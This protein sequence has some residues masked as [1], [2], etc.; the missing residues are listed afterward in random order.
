MWKVED[1]SSIYTYTLEP[2][3]RERAEELIRSNSLLEQRVLQAASGITPVTDHKK[4]ISS[5]RLKEFGLADKPCASKKERSQ[6]KLEHIHPDVV[7]EY[8]GYAMW[9]PNKNKV[10]G[11]SGVNR[12]PPTGG[13]EAT[14][15]V[16]IDG[17]YFGQFCDY[18]VAALVTGMLH[19]WGYTK[20]MKETKRTEYKTRIHELLDQRVPSSES[21]QRTRHEHESGSGF[22]T[23]ESPSPYVAASS[24]SHANSTANANKEIKNDD[25]ETYKTSIDP[26]IQILCANE[27]LPWAERKANCLSSRGSLR[28]ANEEDFVEF[29]NIASRMKRI[30]ERKT[31]AATRVNELRSKGVFSHPHFYPCEAQGVHDFVNKPSDYVADLIRFEEYMQAKETKATET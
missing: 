8:G 2:R 6:I 3:G 9:N 21:D 19:K 24:G 10:G 20:S 7:K 26:L 12:V 4:W 1:D 17:T 23:H 28:T 30:L 14:F 18:R 15:E 16:R 25:V 13:E 22:E 11:Y 5:F 31:N 29:S 27:L